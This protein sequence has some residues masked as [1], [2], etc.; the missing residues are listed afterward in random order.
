VGATEGDMTLHYVGFLAKATGRA[1]LHPFKSLDVFTDDVGRFLM[2]Y[3]EPHSLLKLAE[4]Y[5]LLSG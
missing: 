5:K 1:L 2:S 3:N 4:Y